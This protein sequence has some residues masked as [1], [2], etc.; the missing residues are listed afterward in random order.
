[1]AKRVL[2]TGSHGFIG[3]ALLSAPPILNL[4]FFHAPKF[5]IEKSNS[6]ERLL[7]AVRNENCDTLL[8]L[9]WISNSHLNY[10]QSFMNEVW[11]NQTVAL[12]KA[13]MQNNIRFCGMGSVAEI[14]DWESSNLYA[15]SKR[16]TV[17][18]IQE[19]SSEFT[20]IRPS[21]I[22]AL[23]QGKPTFVKEIKQSKDSIKIYNGN[24]RHDF[25]FLEDV[26]W[27]IQIAIYKNLTG[28]VD[29]G[30]GVSR[31]VDQVAKIIAHEF[32]K[33]E[34][35]ILEFGE[36]RNYKF[37]SLKLRSTGWQPTFTSEFFKTREN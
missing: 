15:L 22:L 10:K 14:F 3:S 4:Q 7:E 31:R 26:L 13:C 28:I 34:P 8:H 25:V 12:A 20:W 30:S 21:Y 17:M 37:D 16:R 6:V 5:L 11:Q 1:M 36:I 32:G 19:F 29:I 27:G 2:V 18:A 23:S 33:P 35:I 9:A 24:D